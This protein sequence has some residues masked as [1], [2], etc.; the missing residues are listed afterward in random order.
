MRFDS[1]A[2]LI[3]S[4]GC[5]TPFVIAGLLQLLDHC[6]E[7][8]MRMYV[9]IRCSCGDCIHFDS[10]NDSEIVFHDD[11]VCSDF[12]SKFEMKGGEEN[13]NDD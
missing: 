3:L 4:A 11:P 2:I 6:I 1:L 12:V 10:C 13:V 7:R 5:M 8:G 9:N